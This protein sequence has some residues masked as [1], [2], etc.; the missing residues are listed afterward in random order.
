MHQEI[1]KTVEHYEKEANAFIARYEEADMS[2]LHETIRAFIPPKS[3]VL[4]VG[5]GSAR[6]LAVLRADGYEVWGVDPVASFVHHARKRFPEIADRFACAGLP[7]L[8]LPETFPDRFDAVLL[9]AVWMHLPKRVWRES[10]DRVV[11]LL[12]PGGRVV[13]SYSLGQRMGDARHFEAIDPDR[14][15]DM[16]HEAGCRSIYRSDSG[17]SLGR[18]TIVWMT[19]VFERC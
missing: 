4:D 2:H 6:D 5:F 19:E 10:V 18:R 17:D 12:K 14:L 1:E 8:P 16:F 15:K 3:G 9:I 13:V 11:S 7:K